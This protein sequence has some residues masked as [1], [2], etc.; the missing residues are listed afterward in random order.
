VLRVKNGNLSTH[1][2]AADDLRDLRRLQRESETSPFASAENGG[3]T[4]METVLKVTV[5]ARETVPGFRDRR[6]Q[7]G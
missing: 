4:V 2:C 5:P 3:R 6:G 7:S 1:P